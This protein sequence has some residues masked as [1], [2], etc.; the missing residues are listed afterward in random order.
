MQVL[1]WHIILC[2]TC[3]YS[4]VRPW[5]R[6]TSVIWATFINVLYTCTIQGM[7]RMQWPL[8]WNIERRQSPFPGMTPHNEMAHQQ[9]YFQ[10]QRRITL[11]SMNIMHYLL[12][13]LSVSKGI[14][15]SCVQDQS[16]ATCWCIIQLSMIFVPDSMQTHSSP[17]KPDTAKGW[18]CVQLSLCWHK[19]DCWTLLVTLLLWTKRNDRYTRHCHKQVLLDQVQGHHP[20]DW[21]PAYWASSSTGH[22]FVYAYVA[23]G[24]MHA[25]QQHCI[26]FGW[27]ADAAAIL[28]CFRLEVLLQ[29]W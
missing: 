17:V 29:V 10:D 4:W 5:N 15:L 2:V 9:N 28:L 20:S 25:R 24:H 21:Y 1:D 22:V 8:Q 14:M 12:S 19:H 3:L 7:T 13:S 26:A 18:E 6:S 16:Q 27:H 11:A 23:K